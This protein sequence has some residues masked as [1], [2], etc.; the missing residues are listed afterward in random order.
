MNCNGYFLIA[1]LLASNAVAQIP[2][3]GPPSGNEF[4]NV[5]PGGTTILP[6]GRLLTPIGERLYTATIFG[7]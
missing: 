1:M 6:N 7:T 3:F 4:A 2:N 5:V